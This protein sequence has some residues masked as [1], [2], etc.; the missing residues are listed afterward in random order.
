MWNR[1]TAAR[2]AGKWCAYLVLLL[3]PGSFFVL[4]AWWCVRMVR[5]LVAARYAGPRPAS[6]A[7]A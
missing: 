1:L 2:P 7:R 5:Q 4:P 3:M 6:A